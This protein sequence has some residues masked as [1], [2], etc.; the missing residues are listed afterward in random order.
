MEGGHKPQGF[1]KPHGRVRCGATLLIF[2]YG[3]ETHVAQRCVSG[4][5]GKMKEASSPRDEPRAARLCF[6]VFSGSSS[7]L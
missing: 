5:S 2:A 7:K 4:N 1:V 3:D 6:V